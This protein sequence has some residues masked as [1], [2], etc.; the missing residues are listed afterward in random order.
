MPRIPRSDQPGDVVHITNRGVER[1]NIFLD[2]RDRRF[3][4]ACLREAF[5]KHGVRLLSDC[6]MPNHYHLLA[7]PSATPI[8]KAMHLLQT[9]Y[10]HR[11]NYWYG[12]NGH[13]FQDRF[14]TVPVRNLRQLVVTAVYIN[15]NPLRAGLVKSPE[16]WQWSSHREILGA[17]RGMLHLDQLPEIAGMTKEEFL[18]AYLERIKA[19]PDRYKS[20]S[21]EQIVEE[22]GILVGLSPEEVSSGGKGRAYTIARNLVN[23]WGRA[24]GF[25]V[26]RLAEVL[27]CSGSALRSETR[28][29]RNPGACPP[30][31]ATG[32]GTTASRRW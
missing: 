13:L 10:A 32:P 18:V 12:R 31:C 2:D 7:A 16:Q 8:G 25:P 22:A 14:H 24:A 1:R 11:F 26:S 30:G 6:L 17:H 4:Q 28:E 20:Y 15:E 29:H 27:G 19:G 9:T 21:L 23:R 3:F 5:D